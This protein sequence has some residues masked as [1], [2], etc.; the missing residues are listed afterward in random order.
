MTE[1]TDNFNS[2]Q[3]LVSQKT[4]TV[5]IAQAMQAGK[6]ES[7]ERFLDEHYDLH[8]G[9]MW[10]P[11]HAADVKQLI[12]KAQEFLE[13]QAGFQTDQR[14]QWWPVIDESRSVADLVPEVARWLT[15][16][17]AFY[18]RSKNSHIWRYNPDEGI[19][20]DD[21]EQLIQSRLSMIQD[22]R[23]RTHLVNEVMNKVRYQSYD[24]QRELGGPPEKIVCENG[25]LNLETLEFENQY[26]KSEYHI[27]KLPVTYTKD[28][29]CPNFQRF[30]EQVTGSE[31]DREAL[32]EFFG[33]CLFKDYPYEIIV[34]LVGEGAN[35]KSI[36][37]NVL[38][39]FLGMDNCTSITPQQLERSRFG[40]AQLHGKLADIAGDIPSRPLKYTGIIKMLC[41]SDPIHAEHKN[42]DPFD[43]QNYAKLIF[44][45]NQ[46]PESWDDTDA[47]YRRFRI[48]DFPNQF[49]PDNPDYIPRPQLM[50]KLTNDQELSGILN[51]ALEGLRRLREQGHL[52]GQPSIDEAKNDY[53]RRSDPAHYFFKEFLY[54]DSEAEQVPK[55]DLYDL[56][57]RFAHA[58]GTTPISYNYFNKKIKRLVPYTYD[59]RPRA[60]EDQRI[61]VWNGIGID[62]ENLKEVIEE[63]GQ[64]GQGI[65]SNE[66]P[67][68]GGQG[69]QG[70][71]S[72]SESLKSQN[73]NRSKTSD[74]VDRVDQLV[75]QTQKQ[76]KSKQSDKEK[77]AISNT[78][79]LEFAKL[80]EHEDDL[81]SD[82]DMRRDWG[83]DSML[84]RKQKLLDGGYIEE[85]KPG[86]WR[87]TDTG[88]DTL[89]ELKT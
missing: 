2:D 40:S 36:L 20:K 10:K 62:R 69:G 47:F 71:L 7:P 59:S 23:F 42:R 25:I 67:G 51:M 4:L 30:L 55:Q 35:G 15:T 83:L 64:T 21:G 85:T 22:A 18:A 43:F 84:S 38:K 14:E 3:W 56:Y 24:F 57:C 46:V 78:I 79:L 49:T 29:V 88:K 50:E 72:Y 37:L 81:V 63:N 89:Q 74:R 8:K 13:L 9:E 75:E 48:I 77:Q 17:Y 61:T 70:N 45:A 31:A 12:P 87:L 41:G 26:E 5:T 27:T 53:I 68:Q 80:L 52:S 44:S 32:I 86:W 76:A 82:D 65:L 54:Q 60:G 58:T 66:S 39:T 73:R 34:M 16:H 19:W 1:A 11:Q 33:Y 28:A 6:W